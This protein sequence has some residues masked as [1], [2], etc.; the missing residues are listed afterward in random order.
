MQLADPSGILPAGKL[1]AA[2]KK[3]L[4]A[5]LPEAVPRPP[6]DA[7]LREAADAI[8]RDPLADLPLM[9]SLA[10]LYE[11]AGDARYLALLQDGWRRAGLL[12]GLNGS[13][14]ADTAA[15]RNALEN[16][17]V[18]CLRLWALTGDD[19]ALERAERLWQNR[20]FDLLQSAQAVRE[21]A[22]TIYAWSERELSVNFLVPGEARLSLKEE[23]VAFTQRTPYPEA[24]RVILEWKT[25][26][27]AP[28]SVRVRLPEGTVPG[29]AYVRGREVPWHLEGR[30]MVVRKQWQPGETLTITFAL[31][32]R[33]ETE[34]AGGLAA[35]SL[36]SEGPKRVGFFWGPLLVSAWRADT[37]MAWEAAYSGDN[38]NLFDVA[39]AR[40]SFVLDGQPL[41]LEGPPDMI[42]VGQRGK[43]PSLAWR[44]DLPGG[45]GKLECSVR[46]ITGYP[47]TCE[48]Q[49]KVTFGSG[50]SSSET[51]GWR[52][53]GVS[54]KESPFP[55]RVRIGD[56]DIPAGQVGVTDA[57][58]TYTLDVGTMQ[59]N[60]FFGGDIAA[61]DVQRLPR[62]VVVS[63]VPPLTRRRSV[64]VWQRQTV[65]PEGFRLQDFG[66]NT[67]YGAGRVVRV[68]V[69]RSKKKGRFLEV[70]TRL[71][72]SQPALIPRSKYLRQGSLLDSPQGAAIL[73]PFN[74]EYWIAHLPGPGRYRIRQLPSS[75]ATTR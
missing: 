22:R 52:L 33:A 48:I 51:P 10:D 47:L 28:L 1:G 11:S 14:R 75:A 50:K 40:D 20:S 6:G 4:A 12:T 65:L 54:L 71:M 24:G 73:Y 5:P 55:V 13:P 29:G 69:I 34:P 37:G 32:F 59:I 62:K 30:R 64:A 61:V 38:P 66:G 31:T 72:R 39:S 3:A 57:V 21:F 2:L 68:R 23:S 56:D 53:S 16:W 67:P 49:G 9:R 44:Y 19:L 26:P 58:T 46:A 36:R 17:F 35:A 70:R 43:L 60:S 7:I 25:P 27:A 63:F 42:A 41:P 74:S 8:A 18:L 15:G 45:A